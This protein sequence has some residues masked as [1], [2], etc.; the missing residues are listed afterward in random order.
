MVNKTA[1]RKAIKAVKAMTPDATTKEGIY[2]DSHGKV[3]INGAIAF[4]AG[5]VDRRPFGKYVDW[6]K[7]EEKI[8]QDV[9]SHLNTIHARYA[10]GVINFSE[11]QEEAERY[12]R[13]QLK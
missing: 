13:Q 12:L 1:I 10:V 4:N 7:L 5:F 3:C 8:G 9:S 2:R 11:M 6:R